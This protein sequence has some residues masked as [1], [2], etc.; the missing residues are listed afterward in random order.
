MIFI[1][2]LYPTSWQHFPWLILDLSCT[3]ASWLNIHRCCLRAS[4]T[5]PF[6]CLLRHPATVTV[7]QVPTL[8]GWSSLSPCHLLSFSLHLPCSLVTRSKHLIYWV[9]YLRIPIPRWTSD[10]S[11]LF[12]IPLFRTSHVSPCLP[13]QRSLF[14]CALRLLFAYIERTRS[15]RRYQAH[16]M[17]SPTHPLPSLHCHWFIRWQCSFPSSLLTMLPSCQRYVHPPWSLLD[18]S[19]AM[20]AAG[21]LGAISFIIFEVLPHIIPFFF[22][23]FHFFQITFDV[24]LCMTYVWQYSG[25]FLC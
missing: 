18:L 17:P 19:V 14:L 11:G 25:R 16:R 4:Q 1:S 3:S 23:Y 21:H 8:I 2:H 20:R 24:M 22:V 13:P 12:S 10:L 6:R 5:P 15:S 9:V 7:I